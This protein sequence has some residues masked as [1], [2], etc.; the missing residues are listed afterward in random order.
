MTRLKKLYSMVGVAA[1]MVGSGCGD[2]D[3]ENSNQP[4]VTRALASPADVKNL[5]IST[6]NS[7]YQ[8]ATENHPA[9][10]TSVTADVSAANFGNFGM[11]FNNVQPRI[12]FE[13]LSAGG[14]RAAVEIPWNDAYATLGAANDALRAFSTGG[15][16]LT[17]AA[18]TAKYRNLAAFAQAGALMHLAIWFDKAFVIDEDFDLNAALPELV[19]YADVSAAALAKWE[20]LAAATATGSATYTA[21]EFP[22]TPALT[23][24]RINRLA[25]TLAALTMAYTPRNGTQNAAVDWAKVAQLADKGIGTGSAGAPFNLVIT[26]DGFIGESCNTWCSFIGRYFAE[27]S[28]MRIDHRL[29]NRMDGTTPPVFAG[30]VPKG[31]SPDARYDTDFEY[32]QASNPAATDGNPSC[33]GAVIGDVT[34]GLYMQSNWYHK[35]YEAHS[36]SAGSTAGRAPVPYILAAE[37]DLIRAEALLR[38]GGSS[39]TA[40]QLINI[41]RVGRGNLSTLTGAETQAVLLA[42]IDYE[43]DVELLSTNGFELPRARQDM[44]GVVRLQAGTIRHLPIPARELETLAL[45][46]YTFGGPGNEM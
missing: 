33:Q 41:S 28:W 21:T 25:N 37:S 11:R 26:G 20:A 30:T 23:T 22:S 34:R 1:L 42:A 12:A 31:T 18:E 8:L 17:D 32:C 9:S 29:I 44:A 10:M 36:R 3:I 5:S 40:A 35:R 2:L 13:N 16:E 38:S 46:I 45:P 7:W 6:M 15:V 39:V 19:P 14:D 4:D 43:R 24:N 27:H